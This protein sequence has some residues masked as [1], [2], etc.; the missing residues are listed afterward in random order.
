[1]IIAEGKSGAS[2]AT[3]LC[4]WHAAH[5]EANKKDTH[6]RMQE[7]PHGSADARCRSRVGA[8]GAA[9]NKEEVKEWMIIVMSRHEKGNKKVK[10]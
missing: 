3:S 1:M 5:P 10:E 9:A 4:E 6:S 8:S 2:R 7:A